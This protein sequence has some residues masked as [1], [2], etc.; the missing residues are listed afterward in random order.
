MLLKYDDAIGDCDCAIGAN[1]KNIK[2][3]FCK[4]K[5]LVALGQ[6]NNAI[7]TYSMVLIHY[8]IHATATKEKEEVQMMQICYGTTKEMFFTIGGGRC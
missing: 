1:G 8:P 6:F 3:H 4:G 7:C 5:V 2:A